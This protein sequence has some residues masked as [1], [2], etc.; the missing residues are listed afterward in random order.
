MH[1]AVVLALAACGAPAAPR[2]ASVAP[3]A[4]I[5]PAIPPV[6][7]AVHANPGEG[8]IEAASAGPIRLVAATPDGGA[9]LTADDLHTVRLWPALDGSHEPRIVPLPEAHQL[10]LG[11]RGDGFMAAV[12]DAAGGLYIATL[13]A[14]GKIRSHVSVAA[15]P[16]WVGIAMATRGLVGW[17]ADQTLV[18]L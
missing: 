1:R 7:P 14:Q 3:A 17:R 15:D 16:E 11:R 8:G 2:S 18:V 5:A 12:L 6:L 10:A 9:A 4:S 13:D